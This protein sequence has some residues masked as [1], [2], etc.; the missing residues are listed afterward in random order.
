MQHIVSGEARHFREWTTLEAFLLEKL[1]T[2]DKQPFQTN[3]DKRQ[4][5]ETLRAATATNRSTFLDENT[6]QPFGER[7]RGPL[8][9][10]GDD[11]YDA[12]RQVWNAMIDRQPALVARCTGTADVIAAVQFAAAHDQIVSV[13]GGGHNIAG[14]AV[15]D[16]GLMIDLSPMRGIRVDP[17]ARRARVQGGATWA[18]FDHEAQ[19]FGLATPGGVIS[20]TGVGG[21]T[22]GGGIGWLSRL[23][24]LAADNLRAVDVVTAEGECVTASDEE[25]PDLFWGIRG[26]GGNFGVVTSFEFALHEVGPEVLAGPTV[27][28][29]QDAP[30]V[31]RHYRD[32][33]GEAPRECCVWV[34][35]LTAPPFPFLPEEVYG[36]KILSVFQFYAG[37]VEQGE[38]V[39]RP[40]RTFG[41]PIADVVGPM[42]YAA[43]QCIFDP[44]YANGARNYWR[45]HNF[46]RLADE[47]LD[48]LVTYAETFPTPQSDMVIHQVGGAVNDV[49]PDAT[50]Y[51]HRDATF[52]VTPGARW[53]DPSGDEQCIAWMRAWYDALARYATGGSY[54]NFISEREGREQVAYGANYDRLVKVKGKYDP[55]NLFRMNQNIKPTA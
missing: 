4:T 9:R 31:L 43:V 55:T 24:G 37:D 3:K 35:L 32:F 44:L 33:A 22:L 49:A 26:G 50:A 1:T 27:Y 23:H 8:L 14:S 19:A 2:P 15:C 10:P 46:T 45:S 16:G 42:P 48:L 25:H 41:H 12:A 18:D 11:G 7:L 21:L 30:D 5:M 20:T 13:R 34:V 54:V 36:T 38:E 39:L 28:R 52:I 53:Q 40:L 47:A 29:L 17:K 6:L 51:P